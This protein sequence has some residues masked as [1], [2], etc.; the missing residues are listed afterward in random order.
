MNSSLPAGPQLVS[1]SDA[2][3]FSSD[4]P[5]IDLPTGVN[6]TYERLQLATANEVRTPLG[7]FVACMKYSF[8]A[9][10]NVITG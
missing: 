9:N 10:L 1:L 8:T 5:H 3:W 2:R 6:G 7:N 4:L